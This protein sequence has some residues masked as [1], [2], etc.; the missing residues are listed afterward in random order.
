MNLSTL[1]L[2]STL[3]C[4]PLENTGLVGFWESSL[5]SK[6]SIGNNIEFKSDGSY[7]S[8][9]TVLVDIL[10]KVKNGKI[11]NAKNPGEAVSFESGASIRIEDDALVL[12]DQEGKEGVRNRITERKGD[13]V[14]GKYKYRHYTGGIAY[15]QYTDDGV[16]KFRLPMRST[17][18]CYI[19]DGNNVNIILSNKESKALKYKLNSKNLILKDKGRE[20]AY[21]LVKEGAWYESD[22]ID[23]KRPNE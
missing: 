5:I 4:Q 11:Y 16:L 7:I 20:S 14:L 18:G 12:I 10:Y 17:R 6:G 9:V 19:I 13:S 22:K 15:E 3:V 23:Y 1:A 2:A 21:K 8:A